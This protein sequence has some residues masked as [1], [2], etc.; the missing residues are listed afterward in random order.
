MGPCRRDGPALCWISGS[1]RPLPDC[2]TAIRTAALVF[3]SPGRD[4]HLEVTVKLMSQAFVHQQPA[5]LLGELR[6]GDSASSEE[7]LVHG[8][9]IIIVIFYVSIS[10]LQN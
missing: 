5:C 3:L 7:T 4:R 2:R 6:T 1:W 10:L 8:F 9:G